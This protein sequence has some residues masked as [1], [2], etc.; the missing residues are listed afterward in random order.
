ML[1]PSGISNFPSDQHR[2]VNRLCG[3]FLLYQNNFY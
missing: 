2:N 1:P 3:L